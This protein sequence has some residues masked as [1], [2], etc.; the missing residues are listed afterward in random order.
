MRKGWSARLHVAFA[1]L[2]TG[3]RCAWRRFRNH[4]YLCARHGWHVGSAAHQP[5]AQARAS[6]ARRV[7]VV[8]AHTVISNSPRRAYAPTLANRIREDFLRLSST[9]QGACARAVTKPMRILLP[10]PGRGVRL[11]L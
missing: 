2:W 10:W 5:D 7:S 8:T 1:A 4:D 11:W 9:G 3:T 6:L